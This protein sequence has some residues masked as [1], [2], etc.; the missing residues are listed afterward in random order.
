MSNTISIGKVFFD[1]Y[2]D[3]FFETSGTASCGTTGII[4][5]KNN[6][7]IE[8][9]GKTYIYIYYIHIH[10]FFHVSPV[11]CQCLARVSRCLAP[12]SPVSRAVSPLSR[13]VSPSVSRL[14]LSRARLAPV[15]SRKATLEPKTMA[16]GS[17]RCLEEATEKFGRFPGLKASTQNSFSVVPPKIRNL[18]FRYY[19]L[20]SDRSRLFFAQN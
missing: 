20:G 9:E 4:K 13:A 18:P 6:E 7:K 17:W 5:K 16:R 11:S 15:F 1:L 19:N 12:V 10:I 3:Y 8:R 2:I 14:P